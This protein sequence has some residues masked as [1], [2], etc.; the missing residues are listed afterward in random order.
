VFVIEE[1]RG[2]GCRE[3]PLVIHKKPRILTSMEYSF[4]ESWQMRYYL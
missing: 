3:K 4:K 2:E 1:P